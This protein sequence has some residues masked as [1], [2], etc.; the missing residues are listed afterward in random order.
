MLVREALGELV[1]VIEP[2]LGEFH[3]AFEAV[4]LGFVFHVELLELIDFFD[5]FVEL[6]SFLLKVLV[7]GF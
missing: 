1:R 2:L 3:V 5:D 7:C 6:V 4:L